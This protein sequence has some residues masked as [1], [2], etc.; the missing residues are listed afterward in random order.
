MGI[1]QQEDLGFGFVLSD[2]EKVLGSGIFF[3]I[4]CCEEIGMI[5]RWVFK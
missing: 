5:L 1:F 2:F 4:G 3:S